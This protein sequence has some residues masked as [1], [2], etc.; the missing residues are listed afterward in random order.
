MCEQPT[1]HPVSLDNVRNF[2]LSHHGKAPQ[3]SLLAIFPDVR[4]TDEATKTRAREEL[5]EILQ[6]IT[7]D[8]EEDGVEY[9]YIAEHY[10]S[11]V[12]YKNACLHNRLTST[13]EGNAPE[14]PNSPSP[15]T[16]EKLS[17]VNSTSDSPR[18][19]RKSGSDSPS[20]KRRLKSRLSAMEGLKH[21]FQ[22]RSDSLD[23]LTSD[24]SECGE[25]ACDSACGIG[26]EEKAWMMACC[27][28]NLHLLK[29]L[30]LKFPDLL[31]YGDFVLGYTALHW[32]AK[33][34]RNDIVEFIAENHQPK[35]MDEQPSKDYL[36]IK[37]HGGF[38]ALHIA[39][40]CG[41]DDVI[42]RLIGLGSNTHARDYNG[43][44][45]KDLVKD[46]VADKIQHKLGRV[47]MADRSTVLK[48][49]LSINYSRSH[50]MQRYVMDGDESTKSKKSHRSPLAKRKLALWS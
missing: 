9:I 35:T 15:L 39:A 48:S 8:D 3:K 41:K 1:E 49:R 22:V 11:N 14:E 40:M 44:K 18:E 4:S 38:T 7:F 21:V 43:N 20:G 32:A 5:K 36:S 30:L 19:S 37:S 29:D 45:P 50:S 46:T 27:S 2:L 12:A 31:S 42:L 25:S 28:G 47:L 13:C 24:D 17:K 26:T 6:L 33:L 10:R 16:A 34:G 23:S